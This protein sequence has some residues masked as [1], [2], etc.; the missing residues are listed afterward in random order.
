[1][2]NDMNAAT[3]RLSGTTTALLAGALLLV[4]LA[5]VAF[6][7]PASVPSTT[8]GN[9]HYE[10]AFDYSAAVRPSVVYPDGRV[11][12]GDPVFRHLVERL[13]VAATV[14]VRPPADSVVER[15][16]VALVADVSAGG[17][18]TVIPLARATAD[19][20]GAAHLTGTLDFAAIE[21]TVDEAAQ[22]AGLNSGSYEVALRA[23]VNGNALVSGADVELEGAPALKLSVDDVDVSIPTEALTVSEDQ[24]VS[25]RR[26]QPNTLEA[27]PVSLRV[28]RARQAAPPAAVALLLAGLVLAVRDRRAARRDPAGVRLLPAARLI[29]TDRLQAVGSIVD[30][31]SAEALARI[32]QEYDSFI[33][34][35]RDRYDSWYVVSDGTTTFRYRVPA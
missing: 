26:S 34:H 27:G 32:A 35:G 3:H 28:E 2:G 12:A 22:L 10:A 29:P 31:T 1:M 16:D 11:D 18:S 8:Q 14:T 21:R 33:F 15:A 24:S 25:E 9:L 30:V 5:A 17:W 23:E 4:L 6:L 7:E 20:Q 19:Q 13:D